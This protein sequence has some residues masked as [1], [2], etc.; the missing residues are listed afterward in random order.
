MLRELPRV[1]PAPPDRPEFA[2]PD[3]PMR[4]VTRQVAF[5]AGGWTPE[6]AA[7]VAALFNGL[8]AEWQ[9]RTSEHRVE[10][11]EDALAR[12]RAGTGL[13]VE[14]GSGTGNA[15][16]VLA[17]QFARVLA[18]DLAIE[19]LRRAPALD[20]ARVQADAARL[21]LADASADAVVLVN[22]LLFPDEV[23][24]V[25]AP[26]GCVVWVNTLGDRTP[27]HLPAADVDRALPGD[28]TGT[29]SE[30]AWGTWCV[31]RRSPARTRSVEVGRD[32]P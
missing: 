16:G 1:V 9:A 2:G 11:I 6:R 13:C 18:M 25:L 26:G 30:A 17:K 14:I 12:G 8:A 24:R 28:W 4:K 23:A 27:I 19:M 29:A 15:S 22:A 5:E 31:L 7:K 10:P 21:P 20:A 3:H 32:N